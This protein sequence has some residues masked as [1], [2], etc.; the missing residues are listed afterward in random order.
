MNEE[1]LQVQLLA[2]ASSFLFIIVIFVVI[3]DRWA[4]TPGGTSRLSRRYSVVLRSMQYTS[5]LSF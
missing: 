4:R 5:V 3:S 1:E 2:V